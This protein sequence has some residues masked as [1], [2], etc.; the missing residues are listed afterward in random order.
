MNTEQIF[1]MIIDFENEQLAGILDDTLDYKA[2][3]SKGDTFLH[4]AARVG[5]TEAFELLLSKG[6]S[7]IDETDSGGC[8]VLM[9]ACAW[10]ALETL[11]LILT[12]YAFAFDINEGMKQSKKTPFT[13]LSYT[14]NKGDEEWFKE[15]ERLLMLMVALNAKSD[16][17]MLES[18]IEKWWENNKN[19]ILEMKAQYYNAALEFVERIQPDNAVNC[20]ALRKAYYMLAET[21]Y[22]RGDPES[23]MDH[24]NL[25]FSIA[26]MEDD[27]ELFAVEYEE[28]RVHVYKVYA[29]RHEGWMPYYKEILQ[30]IVDNNI[31]LQDHIIYEDIINYDI[32]VTGKYTLPQ[33][34]AAVRLENESFLDA[35]TRYEKIIG[36][37][38]GYKASEPAT[39]SDIA[40]AEAK[41][42]MKI[43]QELKTVYMNI[44]N[45]IFSE[46]LRGYC[47]LDFVSAADIVGFFESV[48]EWFQ[49]DDF[50][51]VEEVDVS[52]ETAE[53]VNN[54]Y[55]VFAT[56][57]ENEG[58]HYK[59]FFGKNGKFGISSFCE[60]GL[61][62]DFD[63]LEPEMPLLSYESLDELMSKLFQLL[64]NRE[65][66]RQNLISDIY[67]RYKTWDEVR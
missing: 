42:G 32:R 46:F 22:Y 2:R 13:E 1:N 17:S 38:K 21:E 33:N 41:I 65:L 18:K 47:K 37:D 16:Y 20:F 27:K 25:L 5:N 51:F 56:F 52:V 58:I 29:E 24:L 36:A 35:F 31:P 59:F 4:C 26:D 53:F 8:S 40:A 11:E 61:E 3:D 57:Y 28:L 67:W 66:C 48:Q 64:I 43:P 44:G 12:D 63:I 6:K 54:N 45:G 10:G 60:D 9:T 30:T 49:E 15:K 62:F 55:K 19:D 50:D 7:K 34:Q 14:Q 39:E 23:A